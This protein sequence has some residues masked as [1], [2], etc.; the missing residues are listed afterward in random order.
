M[1]NVIK[2]IAGAQS[3][4]AGAGFTAS[5]FN[6]RASGSVVVAATAI[7][8]ATNLDLLME[9]SAQFA[10]GATTTTANSY[11]GLYLLPLNQD[12][13]TYGGG[14]V[15]GTTLPPQHLWKTNAFTLTGITSGNTLF[16]EFPPIL[17]PRSSFKLAISNI[18]GGTLNASAAAVVSFKTS[19]YN[20]NG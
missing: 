14:A 11:F 18:T 19:N 20:G 13:S 6:S 15:T 1:A 10:N 2:L 5:D 17:L 3:A 9:V 8:N 16:I 4:Y 7:D 12:G